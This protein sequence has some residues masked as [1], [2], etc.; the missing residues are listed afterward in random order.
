MAEDQ[1]LFRPARDIVDAAHVPD[2]EALR[3]EAAADP[4]AFW[5]CT[6]PLP[7]VE[8]SDRPRA[9]SQ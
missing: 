4:N 6:E 2:Y 7:A 3:A 8:P 5:R 9:R 1:T